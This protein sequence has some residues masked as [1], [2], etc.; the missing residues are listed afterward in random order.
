MELI[1][2]KRSN[3]A[4]KLLVL[5]RCFRI[6]SGYLAKLGQIIE[7]RKFERSASQ[8]LTK[9]NNF[10]ALS[11]KQYSKAVD[12]YALKSNARAFRFWRITHNNKK[13]MSELSTLILNKKNK[14]NLS[15]YLNK[16]IS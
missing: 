12:F 8:I 15:R 9:W 2:I 6:W 4:R 11:K 10:S 14:S 16:C 1:K 5:T 7:N 3:S 13:R